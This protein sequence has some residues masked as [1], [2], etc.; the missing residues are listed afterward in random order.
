MSEK[1]K[2]HFSGHA[3]CYQQ[4]RPNYPDAALR[5]SCVVVSRRMTLPGTV[6]PA[7]DRLPWRWRR[8]SRASSPR[9][10]VRNRLNRPSATQRFAISW[11]RRIRP[12]SKPARLIW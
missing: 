3:A 10:L 8:I 2:D 7:T 5:L 4:F 1:E 6:Q 12:R 11:R 9:I